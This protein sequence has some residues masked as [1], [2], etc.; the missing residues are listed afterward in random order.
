ME[1][2]GRWTVSCRWMGISCAM[3]TIVFNPH[4][5]AA[6]TV[7]LSEAVVVVRDGELP[8]AEKTAATVLVEELE[9]SELPSDRCL[10][11]GDRGF[12]VEEIAVR[13]DTLRFHRG[14]AHAR[15]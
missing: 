1:K 13:V 2:P 11:A 10:G 7:D 12:W 5:W 9:I 8:N 15:H 4:A 6:D 14:S 3:C